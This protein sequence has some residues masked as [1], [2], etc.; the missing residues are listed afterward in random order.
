MKTAAELQKAFGVYF[1]EMDKCEKACCYRALLHLT[2]LLP[3]VCASLEEA[4]AKMG[5]RYVDWCAENFP[6]TPELR[7][8]DIFQVRNALFHEG[9]T[10]PTNRAADPAQ[11][12]QYTSFSF[13]EPGAAQVEV[14]QLVAADAT[15]GGK[16]IAI[17]VTK[18]AAGMRQ[19]LCDWFKRLEADH[20]RN[21][22]VEAN[23]HRV[24]R[25]QSKVSELQ[26]PGGGAKVTLPPYGTTSS[27]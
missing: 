19:A 18:L 8:G 3:D 27:T 26:P 13:V 11:R 10:L 6:V 1:D 21:A 5:D 7:P 9:T 2:V 22:I 4:T 23:V 14:H 16:N 17:N 15:R 12:T 25:V 20:A 24:V